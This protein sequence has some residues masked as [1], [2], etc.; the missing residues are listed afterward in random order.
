MLHLVPGETG[1]SE[2]Y[3]R[4]LV[5]A[6]LEAEHDLELVV[7]ASNQ[8]LP[9]LEAEPWAGSVELAGLPFDAR[10]RVRRV[11]AEQTLLAREL[12]NRQ[13]RAPAQPLH[14]GAGR[15]AGTAGDDDPG[16]D[17][18]AL[19]GDARRRP[20]QGAGRARVGRRAPVRARD[21][22]FRG[23]QDGHRPA[24]SASRSTGST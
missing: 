7:L 3:A 4:R 21:R 6:L 24:S 22:D 8:A 15:A 14:H 11:L 16:R 13:G 2:L 10:S 5:P 20:E 19:S 1:G 9:S 18:Q 23:R 17:L 12:G